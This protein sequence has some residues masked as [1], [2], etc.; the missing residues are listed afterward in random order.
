MHRPRAAI[1]SGTHAIF[2]WI[3]VP[4]DGRGMALSPAL[5]SKTAELLPE[6]TLPVLV[7]R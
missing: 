2:E 5:G 4:V 6:S 3:L 7:V 1:R